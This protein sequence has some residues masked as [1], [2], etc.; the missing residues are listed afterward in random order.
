MIYFERPVRERLVKRM[1][2]TL[3][4][5]GLLVLGSSESLSGFDVGTMRMVSLSVYRRVDP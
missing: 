2:S 3:R 5:G 1:R 4:N